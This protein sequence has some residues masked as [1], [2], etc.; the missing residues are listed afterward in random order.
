MILLCL[1][2]NA[3][4]FLMTPKYAELLRPQGLGFLCSKLSVETR[5]VLV[6]SIYLQMGYCEL[7]QILV[8][9][10][11]THQDSGYHL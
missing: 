2:S 3:E 7:K 4:Y 11:S 6:K 10:C 9:M 8:C 1:S 5:L